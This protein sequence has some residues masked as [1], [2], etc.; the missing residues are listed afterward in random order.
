MSSRPRRG[1]GG[2]SRPTARWPPPV[3]ADGNQVRVTPVS[4]EIAPALQVIVGPPE[5]SGT[6]FARSSCSRAKQSG[7]SSRA[8]PGAV[9]KAKWRQSPSRLR[10][11][12]APPGAA[13]PLSAIRQRGRRDEF[14]RKR[15]P[16]RYQ[17]QVID[18]AK[19]GDEI[20]DQVDWAEGIAIERHLKLADVAETNPCLPNVCNRREAAYG[21]GAARIAAAQTRLFPVHR[22]PTGLDDVFTRRL[23]G[24]AG[25]GLSDLHCSAARGARHAA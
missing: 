12:W 9:R 5:E 22:Y 10:D 17:K 11:W 14:H 4:L 13:C 3:H 21:R 7:L 2:A 23:V 15:D 18:V 20:G 6:N 16:D 8:Q 25:L 1:P 24:A 19:Y